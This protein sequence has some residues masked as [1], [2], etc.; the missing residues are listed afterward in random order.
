MRKKVGILLITVLCLITVLGGCGK[1]AGSA[2]GNVRILLT[3]SEMDTFRQTLVEAAGK[4]ADERGVQLEIM[5][6]Q[7]SIENQVSHIKQAVSEDYDVILCAPVSIDTAVELKASAGDIP[8]I[9]INSCPDDKHLKADQYMYVGSDE[10]VAG[11]FQAEYVLDRLADKEEINVVL[12]KG[13]ASHSA[14][15]GRT[16]GVKQA[17]EA[18][19]KKINYVFEDYADWD[20]GQAGE[21]FEIFLKTGVTADCVICNNDTMALGVVAAC[22]EAGI[23]LSQILILGVDATAEGCAAI[24][25]GEMAFTVYQSATGQGQAAIEAAIELASGSSAKNVEGISDDGKYVWVPF[26]KVDSSNVDEY[27]Q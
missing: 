14:T 1:T 21:M 9:F 25:N 11:Q 13:A 15:P 2:S 26:E 18:S 7:G 24:K 10:G 3:L 12:L 8:I 4:V 20:A 19:G 22:K 5:D 6:A 16:K 23:D 17:L 27:A